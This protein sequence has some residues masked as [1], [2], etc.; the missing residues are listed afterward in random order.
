MKNVGKYRLGCKTKQMMLTQHKQCN[1]E[2]LT[3]NPLI[4]EAVRLRLQMRTEVLV[5]LRKVIVVTLK[6]KCDIS[7]IN[8]S[9]LA[10]VKKSEMAHKLL[11]SRY[12]LKEQ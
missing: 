3:M 12:M 2:I 1:A 7:Y 11:L 9:F 4:A 5:N 10:H 6:L 8:D